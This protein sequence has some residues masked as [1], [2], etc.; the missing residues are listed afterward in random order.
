MCTYVQKIALNWISCM[1]I[2]VQ[3]KERELKRHEKARSTLIYVQKFALN[4]KLCMDISHCVP[5]T[6]KWMIRKVLKLLVYTSMTSY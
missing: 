5:G 2:S 1:D 4:W 6:S 3:D